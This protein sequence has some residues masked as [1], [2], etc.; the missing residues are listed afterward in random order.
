M[1]LVC[2]CAR[3]CVST[4]ST[5]SGLDASLL[6]NRNSVDCTLNILHE[7]IPVQVKQAEGKLIR[8]LGRKTQMTYIFP[9]TLKAEMCAR[10]WFSNTDET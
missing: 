4:W 1:E 2:V 10:T 8:H 9:V 7:Y 3:V 6:Q 5:D